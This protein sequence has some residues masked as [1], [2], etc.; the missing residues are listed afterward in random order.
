MAEPITLDDLGLTEKEM[1]TF[2]EGVVE[3]MGLPEDEPDTEE[4]NAQP[5]S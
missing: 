5:T 1:E 3:L 2:R 4:D